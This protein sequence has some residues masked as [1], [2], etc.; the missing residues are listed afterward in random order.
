MLY[1]NDLQSSQLRVVGSLLIKAVG[2]LA[3]VTLGYFDAR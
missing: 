2:A 3:T 1:V